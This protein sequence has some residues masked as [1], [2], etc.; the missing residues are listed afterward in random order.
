MERLITVECGHLG[1][2]VPHYDVVRLLFGAQRAIADF[3][4]SE[5][6]IQPLPNYRQLSGRVRGIHQSDVR[7]VVGTD[8]E[9]LLRVDGKPFYGMIGFTTEKDSAGADAREAI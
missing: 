5:Q 2:A 6:V 1:A 9:Q 8:F 3:L 7:S 4:M